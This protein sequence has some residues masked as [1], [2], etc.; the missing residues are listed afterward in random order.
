MLHFF[1]EIIQEPWKLNFEFMTG[2]GCHYH[3]NDSQNWPIGSG[4]DCQAQKT[5][6]LVFPR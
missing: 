5:F 6:Q 4:S 3:L 2:A 1:K